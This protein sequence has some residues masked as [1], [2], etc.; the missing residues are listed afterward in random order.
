MFS[1][2]LFLWEMAFVWYGV[3]L[4]LT[5]KIILSTHNI[6]NCKEQSKFYPFKYQQHKL[7]IVTECH[8]IS[9]PVLWHKVNLT[10]ISYVQEEIILESKGAVKNS[11]LHNFNTWSMYPPSFKTVTAQLQVCNIKLPV[12]LNIDRQTHTDRLIPLY[13]LKHSFCGCIIIL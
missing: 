5:R 4:V 10:K 12:F 8:L 2:G 7:E 9:P 13:P 11:I 6:I 3:K 1:K